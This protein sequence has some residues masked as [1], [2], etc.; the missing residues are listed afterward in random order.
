MIIRELNKS[1]DFSEL[2]SLSKQFFL[3]YENHNGI[4]KIETLK[5]EF[6]KEFFVK[7]LDN[8]NSNVF[9]AIEQDKIVAYISFNIKSRLSFFKIKKVGEISGLMV[10]K[11]YRKKG[12]AKQLLEKTIEWFKS[13]NINHY[14][15][16][17]SSKNDGAIKF[18][19]SL[20]LNPLRTQL[21]GK[22]K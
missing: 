15:L 10:N 12:I 1:D 7:S 4:F 6:L 11:E 13:K 17:T 18:Y 21:I 20:G 9:I 14:I 2:V 22:I 5:D 19:T 3:E 16:E 8:E